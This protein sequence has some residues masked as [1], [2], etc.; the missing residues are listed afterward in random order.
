M[1]PVALVTGAGRGIGRA[2]AEA[3]AAAGHPVA[4]N[5]HTRRE[6][7]EAVAESIR[8]LGGAAVAIGGD[9]GDEAA[10]A[11]MVAE[12]E[13]T[14]GPIGVLVNNAGTRDDG[15]LVRMTTESWDRVMA[16]NL[17]SAFLCSR[18]VLRNM[19]KAKWGRI[20]SVTSV[21]GIA[22][23]AG[24]TNY[25]A[26]KAG[27][28]GF[29]RA[30]AKEVGTRGITVNAIA[31]GFIETEL[32]ADI[33]EE[34]RRA[35]MAGIGLGRFGTPAE[36]ASVVRFLASEEASYVHGHVLVVDGGLV[37]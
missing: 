9:V 11:E 21:S 33:G 18:A 16:V 1:T 36:V 19:L 26:A 23:N 37:M 7:A 8:A 4:V 31:P 14:L 17:R 27:L 32:I 35:A 15:L 12:A 24:Q 13:R 34:R 30:L 3:L 28:L 22:G 5:Y 20:I 29:T 25:S 2:V 6:T 10:V